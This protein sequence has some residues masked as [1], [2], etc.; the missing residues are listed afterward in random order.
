VAAEISLQKKCKKKKKK[1]MEGRILQLIQRI[2][3]KLYFIRD[4]SGFGMLHGGLNRCAVRTI[5]QTRDTCYANAA[6]NCLLLSKTARNF[7]NTL[8]AKELDA[9]NNTLNEETKAFMDAIRKADAAATLQKFSTDPTYTT[10]VKHSACSFETLKIVNAINWLLMT[11]VDQNNLYITQVET[12]PLIS[13]MPQYSGNYGGV[14]QREFMNILESFQPIRTKISEELNIW[15]E[16]DHASDVFKNVPTDFVTGKELHTFLSEMHDASGKWEFESV[17][18]NFKMMQENVQS[19]HSIVL[20]HCIDGEAKAEWL[21]S[22]SNDMSGSKFDPTFTQFLLV[23]GKTYT[24]LP[25]SKEFVFKVILIVA[26]LRTPPP[27]PHTT[28]HVQIPDAGLDAVLLPFP[29]S[30]LP[31]TPSLVSSNKARFRRPVL[32]QQPK[33][34]G[35]RR[36]K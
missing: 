22:D 30:S 3:Q 5:K 6:W 23:M 10:A 7:I 29:P 31:F 27:P 28:K 4:D 16:G 32:L 26:G 19:E 13:D 12:A 34:I 35:D 20:Y 11:K 17:I 18:V 2:R 1:N 9:G 8:L 15:T 24:N 36:E 21:V 25:D 33:T 14:S